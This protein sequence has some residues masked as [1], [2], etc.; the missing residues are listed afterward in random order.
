MTEDAA[1]RIDFHPAGVVHLDTLESTPV[2]D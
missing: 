2:G 1:I